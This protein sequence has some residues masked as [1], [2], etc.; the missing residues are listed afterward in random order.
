MVKVV[1]QGCCHGDLDQIYQNVPPLA[2]I[3]IICG[4]FEAIRNPTDLETMSVPRKYSKMGDFHKYY[5]GEKEAPVLT[6]F[7]GGN[8]ECL[9]YLRELQYGGWVAPNIYYLGHFGVVWY[10]G[11]RISGISGIWNHYS[12]ISS[13]SARSTPKYALPYTP[14]TIKSIY[15]VLPKNYLKLLVS[16]S[17]DIVVSHDWPQYVWKWG[18]LAQ[19]LRN[20]PFFRKDIDSGRLGS[21]LAK[22]ALARLRPRY[23]FS[24]HLHTRFVASVKHTDGNIHR[25]NP[26]SVNEKSRADKAKSLVD[27][28]S[29]IKLD[30]DISESPQPSGEISL[31]IDTPVVK[32]TESSEI[33][34]DIESEI[35]LD[36]DPESKLDMTPHTKLFIN[37]E[38][39]LDLDLEIKSVPAESTSE[40]KL[41]L[42]DGPAD[43][44]SVDAH[45]EPISRL[46]SDRGQKRRKTDSASTHFLALDKC[47]PRRRFIEL[48]EIEPSTE[49][50]SA[51]NTDIYYDARAIAIN[52]V[53]EDFVHTNYS[54]WI[55]INPHDLLHLDRIEPLMNEFEESVTHELAKIEMLDLK[56]PESF[57]IIAPGS[58]EPNAPLK[59]WP[60]NQ[61]QDYCQKFGVRSPNLEGI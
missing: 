54:Q 4:D 30:I 13:M 12:F 52:K 27:E 20:K 38:I 31:D 53:I 24:L 21:P 18:N 43:L 23:W 2:D 49:H 57:Q 35:K 51:A 56:V 47:L 46:G 40:I 55:S 50:V 39:N 25:N 15:H 58:S 17:S 42:D 29:E 6:V 36:I 7:V 33:K 16:L 59:Y 5:L 37:P 9:L 11:L 60:N 34:L 61:T 22:N 3:L 41:D 8:H 14:Q 26:L 28:S 10:M 19:L 48:V 44:I 45:I 32:T 1:V